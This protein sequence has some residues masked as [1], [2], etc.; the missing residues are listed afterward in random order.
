MIQ[1]AVGPG[2]AR[3]PGG[4][5]SASSPASEPELSSWMF[6]VGAVLVLNQN[7][8]PLNVCNARRAIVLIDLGK[9]E[10]LEVDGLVFRSPSREFRVPSVIRLQRLVKRPRP[11]V[12]LTRRE[13]F[14]RDQYTCQYCGI[15]AKDLT[16]DHVIPR[17]R[18]GTHIW[19]NVVSACQHCNHHKGG[20]SL[21]EAQ[22]KLKSEPVEPRATPRYLFGQYLG[23]NSMWDKFLPFSD[24]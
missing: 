14:V 5:Q 9:A 4:R 21:E 13:V 8:E 17:H 10:V 22:M 23:V 2:A 19:T 24:D 15:S 12:R 7:Y 11:K 6:R 20:R 16:V 3:G 1:S 18:G